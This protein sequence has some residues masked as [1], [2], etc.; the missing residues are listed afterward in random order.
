MKIFGKPFLRWSQLIPRDPLKKNHS[1]YCRLHREYS[2]TTYTCF[3]LKEDIKALI[4]K[5]YLGEFIEGREPVA[6]LIV[7]ISIMI[8]LRGWIGDLCHHIS[9]TFVLMKI[10]KRI[11]MMVATSLW[12]RLGS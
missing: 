3:E 1:K 6:P 10:R 12:M 4:R 2:H 7:N 9:D 11:R 5:G 8:V